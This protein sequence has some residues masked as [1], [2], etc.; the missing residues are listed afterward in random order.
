MS[1]TLLIASVGAVWALLMAELVKRELLPYLEYKTPP[2]YRSLLSQR[3]EPFLQRYRL[4]VNSV[5]V[6]RF[7]A[8]SEPMPDGTTRLRSKT[9]YDLKRGLPVDVVKTVGPVSKLESTGESVLD[10][11]YRL[12]TF[13]LDMHSSGITAKMSGERRED[14]LLVKYSVMGGMWS[15]DREIPI[16]PD[17]TLSDPSMPFM[18]GAKLYVGKPWEVHGLEPDLKDYVKRTKL[19]AIV[20][21]REKLLHQGNLVDVFRVDVKKEPTATTV[22][23]QVFVDD[24]GRV[25]EQRQP[26]PGGL[27]LR[28]VLDEERVLTPDELKAW[29]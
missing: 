2:S 17:F 8:V 3:K 6:G 27:E 14:R 12:S 25:L 16:E 5:V 24:K 29:K 22:R 21:A 13:V 15:G 18:G 26:I 11:D 19:Y 20:E 1:R 28:F 10:R 7:E 23:Y 4:V 9:E